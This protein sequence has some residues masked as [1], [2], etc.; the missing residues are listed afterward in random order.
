MW[1][2]FQEVDQ[3]EDSVFDKDEFKNSL[4][5]N[6]REGGKLCP[7]CQKKMNKFNYR[8]E[9]LELETC[10]NKD[11]FWLDK[12]EEEKIPELME[13]YEHDLERKLTVEDKWANHLKRLQSPSFF[14]NLKDLFKGN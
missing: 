7:K 5:T 8:W 11:G 14:N 2:D 10:P 9:E 13:K 3:L 1:L 4:V 6:I 12:G